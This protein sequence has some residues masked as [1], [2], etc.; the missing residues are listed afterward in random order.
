MGQFRSSL[1]AL[2]LRLLL[3]GIGQQQQASTTLRSS[4]NSI[5]LETMPLP[6]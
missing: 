2:Q 5:T 6:M 1:Q 4:G 3:A